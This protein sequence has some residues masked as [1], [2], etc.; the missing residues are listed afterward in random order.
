[1]ECGGHENF[2]SSPTANSIPDW[3]PL[4]LC[5]EI[6]HHVWPRPCFPWAA[7]SWLRQACSWEMK[8]SLRGNWLKDSLSA[9]LKLSGTVLLS[10]T[11]HSS[12]P[13]SLPP[14]FPSLSGSDQHHCLMALP[15]LSVWRRQTGLVR[16]QR[17]WLNHPKKLQKWTSTSIPGWLGQLCLPL[18][19]VVILGSWCLVLRRAPGSVG[20]LLLP[21]LVL[22]DE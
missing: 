19:Q 3:Q 16:E 14:I 18:A 1:M 8:T 10:K 12:F 11:N 13:S 4:L 22:S 15:A 5:F 20:S 6:Q 2:F 17:D 21:L 7:L 9:L